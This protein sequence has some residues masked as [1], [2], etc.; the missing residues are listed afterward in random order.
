[1]NKTTEQQY[2]EIIAEFIVAFE[3]ASAKSAAWDGN[4]LLI[5][6]AKDLLK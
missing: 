3:K 4:R 5:Q 6:R 1:M 2:R